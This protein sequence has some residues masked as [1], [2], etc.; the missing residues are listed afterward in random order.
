M[1]Q[2]ILCMLCL[3][4]W[5]TFTQL[6]LFCR[7]LSGSKKR[8]GL[9]FRF[10]L[11][12]RVFY[13]V[14]FSRIRARAL[15]LKT[16]PRISLP[17]YAHRMLNVCSS[18]ALYN[19]STPNIPRNSIPLSLRLFPRDLIPPAARCIYG[20]SNAGDTTI[21]L[22]W[23]T[24]ES[25]RMKKVVGIVLLNRYICM[26]EISRIS[27]SVSKRRS[28][29]SLATLSSTARPITRSAMPIGTY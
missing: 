1:A 10:F 5:H 28:K 22:Y 26:A 6:R 27:K 11:L 3:F 24:I 15:F 14:S 25:C 13:V 21:P 9:P 29:R 18:Y 2:I 20:S 4:C 7:I 16:F 17:S 19:V 8:K 23:L 12:L